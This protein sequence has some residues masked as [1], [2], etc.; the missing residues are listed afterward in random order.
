[1]S[2]FCKSAGVIEMVKSDVTKSNLP[3]G[4]KADLLEM[5]SG[6]KRGCAYVEVHGHFFNE[7]GTIGTCRIETFDAR[8]W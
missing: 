2:F 8:S 4:L 6:S 1:M 5:L 7:G 3:A